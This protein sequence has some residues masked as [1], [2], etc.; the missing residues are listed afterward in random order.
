MPGLYPCARR[1][2]AV[3]FLFCCLFAAT[4]PAS[5]QCYSGTGQT[6][7]A[8][9]NANAAAYYSTAVG[10]N[11][12]ALCENSI[13]IGHSALAAGGPG[14]N[15]AVGNSAQV[16]APNGTAVGGW[17]TAS[18]NGAT[19]LGGGA[20]ASGDMSTAVGPSAR[21]EHYQSTALGGS[22]Q[23]TRDYQMM[24]GTGSSTYTLAG[25]ASA[26]STAAQ[27][28]LNRYMVTTDE[29]GNLAVAAIPTSGSSTTIV[30]DLT[31]GG[32]TEALSAEQGKVLDARI[33]SAS[34]GA[35]Y[36]LGQANS[37]L[38]SAAMAQ[39]TADIA[40]DEVAQANQ[41]IANVE[42]TANA[43]LASAWNAEV[44]AT[45][46]QTLAS[47]A[48]QSTGA[49]MSGELD[50][51][52]NRITNVGDPVLATDAATKGYVDTKFQGV[53]S[54]LTAVEEQTRRNTDGVAIAI[55]MGGLSLPA[56]KDVA[57]GANISFFDGSQALATQGAF[58]VNDYMVFNTGIGF[59][60]GSDT[61]VGGRMGLMA[62]W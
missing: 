52:G 17:S 58:K 36:A 32:T 35:A 61:T 60:L 55:A 45:N 18:G 8:G 34:D 39:A 15:T 6:Y 62:A 24:F 44:I 50:M 33:T 1:V 5:A 56:N 31:T 4:Q 14:A 46:A 59:A 7:Q 12:Q 28:G 54:R 9:M 26:S 43:A 22:A 16:L 47:N 21:A 27:T 38:T 48:M 2:I 30:D 49:T 53:T 3:A 42:T 13:A 11:A 25:L 19:A 51:G 29:D 20:Y 41:D 57:I 23:T 10:Y 40:R 37:A